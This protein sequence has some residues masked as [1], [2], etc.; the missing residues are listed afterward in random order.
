MTPTPFPNVGDKISS[1]QFSFGIHKQVF[2]FGE[3][4]DGVCVDGSTTNMVATQSYSEDERI[5]YAIKHRTQPPADRQIDF[6][7]Y[8]EDRGKATFVVEYAEMVYGQ[9]GGHNDHPTELHVVARK[10]FSSGL[11][12]P[13]GEIIEFYCGAT[14][15]SIKV[16]EIRYYGPMQ[17][18][19]I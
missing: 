16:D 18:M 6:G 17:R 5:A 1:P 12:N 9:S 13:N 14:S 15:S 2:L 8:D 7:A 4:H 10:L 19:F 3:E 11:Y